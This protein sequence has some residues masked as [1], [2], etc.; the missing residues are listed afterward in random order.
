MS[1]TPSGSAYGR[2]PFFVAAL[3][4]ASP[5]AASM[6]TAVANVESERNRDDD[7]GGANAFRSYLTDEETDEGTAGAERGSL[8]AIAIG[9]VNASGTDELRSVGAG[10]EALAGM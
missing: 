4:A 1:G 8:R 3:L 10:S 5:V 2:A 7:S 6:F 9:E